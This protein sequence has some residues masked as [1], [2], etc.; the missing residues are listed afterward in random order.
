MDKNISDLIDKIAELPSNW[1]DGGIVMPAGLRAIAEHAASIGPIRHSVETGSGA[2]TL[3]FS[4]LS[5][6]HRVF[7]VDGGNSI[8]EVRKSPLFKS[9]NVTYVEGFT[10]VTLP[11]YTLPNKVQIALIDGPHGY[12]FPDLEYFYFYPIIE[13]GGLL[14]V[15]DIPIPTIARMFDII[16]ADDMFE[17]LDIVND[18]MAIFKRTSAATIDPH[19]DSWFLQ[20]YNRAHYKKLTEHA[21][22]SLFDSVAQPV[23]KQALRGASALTPKG[24]KERLPVRIKKKLWNKM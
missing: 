7:A 10:Q 12:P 6:D 14:V 18:K 5:A 19:S 1:H 13:T 11:N 17:L 4:H 22:P 9:E 8:S 24:L 21:S 15:D 3:L 16:K 20:G 2:T 23:L